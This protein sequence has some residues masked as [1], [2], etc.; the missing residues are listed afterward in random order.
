MISLSNMKK[1]LHFFLNPKWAET[2]Y[3][4]ILDDPISN[5][6]DGFFKSPDCK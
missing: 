2:G 6:Q 3:L 1:K 5:E 4:L